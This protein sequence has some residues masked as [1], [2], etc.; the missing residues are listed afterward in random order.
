[1]LINTQR[2]QSS[3]AADAM[4]VC[5]AEFLPVLDRMME[6]KQ[7]YE[8]HEFGKKYNS[9]TDTLRQAY[10]ELGVTEYT[11]ATGDIVDKSRMLVVDSE[12]SNDYS[13]DTVLRPVSM[14]ME[15][16]GYIVR[17]AECVASLGPETTTP[18]TSP[19][20]DKEGDD[21]TETPSE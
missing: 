10:T 18:T 1:M 5:L 19:E 9:L 6:L 2:L 14:G 12:Y 17:Y 16:Q 7:Q 8:T 4:A 21:D 20:Q 3:N 11:I 13:A 15:L